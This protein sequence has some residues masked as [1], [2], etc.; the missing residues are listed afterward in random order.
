MVISA[1]SQPVD[2]GKQ[3]GR[4]GVYVTVRGLSWGGNRFEAKE[5][6]LRIPFA[7]DAD[8]Q[9]WLNVLQEHIAW[10]AFMHQ[11]TSMGSFQAWVLQRPPMK[12]CQTV[13]WLSPTA[14][15]T[16]S[17]RLEFQSPPDTND[18]NRKQAILWCSSKGGDSF[19]VYVRKGKLERNILTVVGTKSSIPD[20]AEM[21]MLIPV[22]NDEREFVMALQDLIAWNRNMVQKISFDD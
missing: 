7:I 11:I 8:Y 9:A 3:G 2:F 17:V 21:H 10:N 16:L 5:V 18:Q 20:E 4:R 22:T 6:A 1:Q 14:K 12:R 15:N 13:T 19:A